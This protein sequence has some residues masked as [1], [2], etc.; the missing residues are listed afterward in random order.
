MA[1][2]LTRKVESLEAAFWAQ[3]EPIDISSLH[4]S[5][6]ILANIYPL[7]IPVLNIEPRITEE[8]KTG[9]RLAEIDRLLPPTHPAFLPDEDVELIRRTQWCL[10]QSREY[11]DLYTHYWDNRLAYLRSHYKDKDA[12]GAALIAFEHDMNIWTENADY[13]GYQVS[14]EQLAINVVEFWRIMHRELKG[15]SPIDEQTWRALLTRAYIERE[16]LV[17]GY[18]ITEQVY[19]SEQDMWK[20]LREDME[21]GKPSSESEAARYFR[22]LHERFPRKPEYEPGVYRCRVKGV[23]K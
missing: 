20:Q 15:L 3:A 14:R 10:H 17:Y 4:E 23:I 9:K 19:N 21:A 6:T 1:T 22:D 11:L 5:V 12:L 16:R 18:E 8:A 2:S 13:V 7:D